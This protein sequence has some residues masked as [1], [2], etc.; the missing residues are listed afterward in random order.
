MNQKE[1]A[2]RSETQGSETEGSISYI[3]LPVNQ[4]IVVGGNWKNRWRS[5]RLT[6]GKGAREG[7]RGSLASNF[8]SEPRSFVVD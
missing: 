6:F 4:K 8:G 1:A 5:L 2:L 3:N 7:R